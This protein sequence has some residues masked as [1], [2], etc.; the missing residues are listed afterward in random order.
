MLISLKIENLDK[1][2]IFDWE[3][4]AT[5]PTIIS[6]IYPKEKVETQISVSFADTYILDQATRTLV[7]S[8]PVRV[9]VA[10]VG[11]VV[12][13]KS[14]SSQFPSLARMLA[15]VIHTYLAM[16]DPRNDPSVQPYYFPHTEMRISSGPSLYKF[17]DGEAV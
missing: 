9:L 1:N 2:F 4:L 11:G 12:Q 17:V 16:G 6:Q 13:S 8:Q 14:I 5:L 10:P 15:S 3:A 7:P